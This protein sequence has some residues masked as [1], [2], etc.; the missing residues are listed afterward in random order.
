MRCHVE[1]LYDLTN[2]NG[3]DED[4]VGVVRA[5]VSAIRT[6]MTEDDGL[7]LNIYKLGRWSVDGAAKGT[8]ATTLLQFA[9][10]C[11]SRTCMEK[12]E[13]KDHN[14]DSMA[15]LLL[16]AAADHKQLTETL[17]KKSD[18]MDVHAFSRMWGRSRS[19]SRYN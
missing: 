19:R 8:N 16:E 2:A 6:R 3:D 4:V 9:M 5:A 12:L 14:A 17:P 10:R 18:V 11:I 1:V 15:A 13:R 7:I